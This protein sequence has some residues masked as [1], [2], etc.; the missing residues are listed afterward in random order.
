VDTYPNGAGELHGFDAL[1]RAGRRALLQ[2][3]CSSERRSTAR[4]ARPAGQYLRPPERVAAITGV[5]RGAALSA[6]RGRSLPQARERP[7]VIY[8]HR[9]G[10]TTQAHAVELEVR[11]NGDRKGGEEGK[12]EGGVNYQ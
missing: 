10:L 9:R 12:K 3:R 8:R 4:I 1:C 7:L 6:M 11:G 5:G 2:P